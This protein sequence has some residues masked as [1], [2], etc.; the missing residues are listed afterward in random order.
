M[1]NE[2]DASAIGAPQDVV[3]DT[4]CLVNLAAIDGTLECL[5]AFGLTWYVPT[6]VQAEG[7]FIRTAI[8]SREVRRIDLA[9]AVSAGTVHI[10]DPVDD[11]E[12]GLYVEFALNLDDGEAMALA[13]TKNRGWTLATDD[14]KARKKADAV[15]VPVVTTPELVERWATRVGCSEE[16]LATALGRVEALARFVPPG[17][18]PGAEWWR[19]AV[20]VGSLDDDPRQK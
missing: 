11:V 3:L 9:A 10:C 6:A 8:D 2:Q 17:D 13:I 20:R 18:S 16:T 15:G 5:A 7:I 4:C 1:L 19:K 12:R 14:R